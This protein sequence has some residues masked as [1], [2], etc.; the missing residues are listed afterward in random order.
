MPSS[1][2]FDLVFLGVVLILDQ[3]D[4]VNMHT[5]VRDVRD[6]V[7][8]IRVSFVSELSSFMHRNK[9]LRRRGRTS[10]E[11]THYCAYLTQ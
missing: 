3:I 11:R 2:S 6:V 8:A 7:R 5:V 4:V 1:R 9:L 10:N